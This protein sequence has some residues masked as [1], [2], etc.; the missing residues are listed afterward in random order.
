MQTKEEE[1]KQQ[2]ALYANRIATRRIYYLLLK[3]L[4][5]VDIPMRQSVLIHTTSDSGKA[6]TRNLIDY[7]DSTVTGAAHAIGKDPNL[8]K[9]I[10]YNRSHV[11]LEITDFGRQALKLAE[12]MMAPISL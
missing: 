6:Y 9:K 2:L 5:E 12:K 7:S 11:T 10:V 1:N 4:A 3:K 8:T